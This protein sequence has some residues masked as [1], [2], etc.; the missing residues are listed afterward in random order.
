MAQQ[1]LESSDQAA[2][3]ALAGLLTPGPGAM[4]SH[5]PPATKRVAPSLPDPPPA[6]NSLPRT[7]AVHE[8]EDQ[9]GWFLVPHRFPSSM[10]ERTG[11]LSWVGTG[12]R[13]EGFLQEAVP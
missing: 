1:E 8:V 13:R 7:R 9:L 5:L 11:A 10:T 4:P 12:C 2:L 3:C 6:G